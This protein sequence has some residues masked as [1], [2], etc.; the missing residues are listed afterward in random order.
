M[1]GK[2]IFSV[3]YVSG[4]KFLILL[5]GFHGIENQ[6]YNTPKITILRLLI[7]SDPMSYNLH[8]IGCTEDQLLRMSQLMWAKSIHALHSSPLP[9]STDPPDSPCLSWPAAHTSSPCSRSR[10]MTLTKVKCEHCGSM[11]KRQQALIKH[12]RVPGVHLLKINSQGKMKSF[13]CKQCEYSTVAKAVL[14]G[15]ARLCDTERLL[16]WAAN[17]Q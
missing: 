8:D 14:M 16:W 17:P 4:V 13:C 1:I 9:P 11:F 2:G 10:S 6:L 3:S 5:L 12:I 7:S 15:K